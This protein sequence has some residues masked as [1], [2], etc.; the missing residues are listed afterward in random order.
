MKTRS[1]E[2]PMASSIWLSSCPARPTKGSPW[3]SSSAPGASPTKITSA[4][5]SPAP[6]TAFVRVSC[7]GHRVHPLTSSYSS[8]SS[9]RRSSAVIAAMLTALRQRL[10]LP[11]PLGAKPLL[12]LHVEA[13]LGQLFRF[14]PVGV[15]GAGE[16]ARAHLL[17][18]AAHAADHLL[19]DLGVALD[20]FRRAP[21]R[22][23]EQIVVDEHLAG[24]GRAGAD[25]NRRDFELRRD[26]PLRRL[27]LG[28]VAAQGG[29]RLRGQADVA[30]HRDAGADDR[31]RPL[32]RG[33]P[34]LQLDH[35]AA[36]LLY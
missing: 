13:E 36:C 19:V 5:A 4:S 32:D 2:R 21:G 3:R 1:R 29:G 11:G 31:P 27:A 17:D 16:A 22:D 30:H 9:A 7:R 18:V 10:P 35:L 6:N 15:L 23:P 26:R 34:R 8:T 33:P 24:G 28:L 25:P 20:E 14:D 12:L